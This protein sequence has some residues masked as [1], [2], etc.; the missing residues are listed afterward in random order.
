MSDA[1]PSAPDR[2]QI[3]R[4]IGRF[5]LGFKGSLGAAIGFALLASVAFALLPWPIR[6]I[7]DGV[8]LNDELDLAGIATFDTETDGEKL[9]AA[10]GLAIAYLVLQLL[11]ALLLSASF[12]WFAKTALLMI[13]TLRGSML[14]HLRRLS[15]GYHASTSTGDTIFRSINGLLACSTL[16]CAGGSSKNTARSVRAR[17]AKR[18]TP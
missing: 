14:S 11:A 5:M 6:Y 13:H 7:I 4:R 1:S 18:P 17:S 12:W 15:L 2:G 9:T 3:W 8:L 10:I 16:P